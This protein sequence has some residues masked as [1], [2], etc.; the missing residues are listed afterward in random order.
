M[1]ARRFPRLIL[2]DPGYTL[3][4]RRLGGLILELARIACIARDFASLVLIG[5]SGTILAG[6]LAEL[7]LVRASSAVHA[8]PAAVRVSAGS[9]N[10]AGLLVCRQHVTGRPNA[11]RR[12]G[13]RVILVAGSTVRVAYRGSLVAGPIL[14]A[15]RGALK[16][17]DAAVRGRG[18]TRRGGTQG[19][20]GG[21]RGK[22]AVP[23]AAV[24]VGHRGGDGDHA[25][26]AHSVRL[27][28]DVVAKG[29]GGTVLLRR[30]DACGHG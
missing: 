21:G 16:A 12:V 20:G 24:G 26:T 4:A 5:S 29:D 7:V 11:E 25:Q 22:G 2:V 3:L 14:V 17:A 28:V 8:R 13:Q 18:G 1:V 19:L 27:E 30:C 9:T 10:A 15:A 23:G 6:N